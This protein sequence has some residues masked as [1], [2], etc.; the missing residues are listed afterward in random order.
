MSYD[1]V[2]RSN[3]KYE[4]AISRETAHAVILKI[5]GVQANGTAGFTIERGKDFYIE[6]DVE[7]VDEE[8]NSGEEE[9]PSKMVNCINF[10]V[11]AAF[12]KVLN[13]EIQA[14]QEIADGV[15]WPL[16]DLQTDQAAIPLPSL[17][18][19]KKTWWQ[20]WK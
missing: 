18:P 13:D 11:P 7:L 4:Q 17:P 9:M 15:G 8:G 20:F 12:Q 10:H 2:A 16:I 3:D 19:P 1:L 5:P 14:A 6:V